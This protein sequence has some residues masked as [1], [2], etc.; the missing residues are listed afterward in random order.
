MVVTVSQLN[1]RWQRFKRVKH[2]SVVP[3]GLIYAIGQHLYLMN[4]PFSYFCPALEAILIYPPG[5][6]CNRTQNGEVDRE[7][8]ETCGSFVHTER[9]GVTGSTL[10]GVAVGA[11]QKTCLRDQEATGDL[12]CLSM[13]CFSKMLQL[14]ITRCIIQSIVDHKI[15][16]LFK[17]L[18]HINIH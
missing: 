16:I 7:T 12:S 4:F 13:C 9:R 5:F 15:T 18:K 11:P 14:S 6:A 1:Q 3:Y 17:Y 2:S 10:R 8:E